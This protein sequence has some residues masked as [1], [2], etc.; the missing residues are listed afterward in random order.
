MICKDGDGRDMQ[1]RRLLLLVG[2]PF[3]LWQPS[4]P[5]LA[6]GGLVRIL[7]TT[8]EVACYLWI[9]HQII[10]MDY[11]LYT[12]KKYFLHCLPVCF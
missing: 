7:C 12:L 1:E 6:A 4:R 3:E 11:L 2:V 5:P 9:I 10:E 8:A